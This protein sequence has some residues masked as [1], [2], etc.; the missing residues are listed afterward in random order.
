MRKILMFV[1]VALI[2]LLAARAAAAAKWEKTYELTG[3]PELTVRADDAS[4]M[5]HAWDRDDVRAVLTTRNGVNISTS[6]IQVRE[7]QT[8]NRVRIEVIEPKPSMS[9]RVSWE[10]TKLEIWMPSAGVLDVHTGDGRIEVDGV[11][12]SLQLESSDGNII[13]EDVQGDIDAHTGDGKILGSAIKGA[14]RGRSG[15]GRIEVSGM[16]GELDLHTSD[17]K[18]IAEALKGS[19]VGDGWSLR[20]GDG[21]VSLYVPGDLA[22][23]IEASTGD[24]RI[25]F[26]V[27]ITSEGRMSSS[28]LRGKLNGGGGTI[29]IRTSDG[30]IQI[31]PLGGSD[32]AMSE[33]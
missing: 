31:Q 24:G 17:G 11:T 21:R 26:D 9:I 20:S 29:M 2:G 32:E 5:V 1:M 6:S 16:F 4:I 3:S 8:G 15:D 27:P 28:S 12:G 33:T 18:I 7:D 25:S 30:S 23:D 13:L 14:L 19:T 22:A 10:D